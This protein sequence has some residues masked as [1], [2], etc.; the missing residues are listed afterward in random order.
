MPSCSI[1]FEVS[2]LYKIVQDYAVRSVDECIIIIWLLCGGIKNTVQC[3][4]VPIA[5][6]NTNM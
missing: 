5:M 3:T 6:L 2:I 1:N 4:N